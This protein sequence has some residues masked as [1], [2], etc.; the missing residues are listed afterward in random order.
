M[1]IAFSAHMLFEVMYDIGH[2]MVNFSDLVHVLLPDDVYQHL[3]MQC[4][5]FV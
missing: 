3:N 4:L 1:V 2:R 5:L